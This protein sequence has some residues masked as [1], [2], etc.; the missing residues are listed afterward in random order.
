MLPIFLTELFGP[1][2]SPN[3]SQF[4]FKN[5]CAN[6][7]FKN[8][9]KSATL[10]PLIFFQKIVQNRGKCC[11]FFSKTSWAFSTLISRSKTLNLLSIFLKEFLFSI[12]QFSAALYQRISD[13]N[14]SVQSFAAIAV[15]GIPLLQAISQ[16][17]M[18]AILRSVFLSI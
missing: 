1:F 6:S 12:F 4:F 13:C 9:V 11:S 18:L 17:E 16:G 8:W 5:S 3:F 14:S 7:I 10:N 2:D 15:R